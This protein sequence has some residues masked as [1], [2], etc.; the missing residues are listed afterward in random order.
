MD[1]GTESREEEQVGKSL[2]TGKGEMWHEVEKTNEK[3]KGSI[4]RKY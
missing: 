3:S 1:Q 2:I 4:Y